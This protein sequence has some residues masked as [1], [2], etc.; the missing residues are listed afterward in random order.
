VG[1][2]S[3][4]IDKKKIHIYTN[5]LPLPEGLVLG[6]LYGEW[7]YR[8][9]SVCLLLL[10]NIFFLCQ[11]TPKIQQLLLWRV[12]TNEDGSYRSRKTRSTNTIQVA[13]G[14]GGNHTSLTFRKKWSLIFQRAAHNTHCNMSPSTDYSTDGSPTNASCR[15]F[16]WCSFSSC[17]FLQ[18]PDDIFSLPVN[19]NITWL[20][21]KHI[22]SVLQIIFPLH[23][24]FMIIKIFSSMF[25]PLFQIT[26]TV[27]NIQHSWLWFQF[28]EWCG[29]KLSCMS[30]RC[31]TWTLQI[32][33]S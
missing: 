20:P 18:M 1:Y 12:Y 15:I 23:F 9:K 16:I 26:I 33:W 11:S 27:Y 3:Y 8:Y 31:L 4:F 5:V 13:S 28:T 22:F 19:I 25:I 10:A 17:K 14:K 32:L 24:W 29:T 30:N 2:F 6:C 21:K 7:N